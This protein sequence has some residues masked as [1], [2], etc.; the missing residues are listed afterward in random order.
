MELIDKDA[1]IAELDRL[2]NLE[3]DD[4]S[5]LS[6]GKKLILRHILLFLN[7]LEVKEEATTTDAF[8]EKACEWMKEN[9][10]KHIHG[11]AYMFYKESMIEEF[12]Q[13]MK[14]E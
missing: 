7:T 1:L 14:G 6:F 3:Y 2:Y 9:V 10:S 4:M 11:P 13:A 8:I 12:K 5:N